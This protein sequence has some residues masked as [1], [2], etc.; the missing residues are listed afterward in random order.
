[1]T[2]VYFLFY[3]I[4]EIQLLSKLETPSLTNGRSK[5]SKETEIPSNKLVSSIESIL[6]RNDKKH[7]SKPCTEA[8]LIS[9]SRIPN[10][11]NCSEKVSIT[12]SKRI[13][14]NSEAPLPSEKLM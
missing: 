11:S 3:F 9:S 6:W 13:P 7:G 10:I 1:M 4:Q 5:T 8:P 12:E 2:S 14:T